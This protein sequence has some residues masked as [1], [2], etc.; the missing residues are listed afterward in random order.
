MSEPRGMSGPVSSPE[1]SVVVPCYNESRNLPLLLERLSAISSQPGIEVVLVN[2]GSTDDSQAVLD[3]LL[4][5]HPFAR[6]VLVPV[7]RGYGYGILS[8][9]R[10]GRGEFLSWTHADLQT[11]PADILRALSIARTSTSPKSTYVKG[12]RRGRPILDRMFTAGMGVFETLYFR[13]S[14]WDVNA[15]PNLFHKEFFARWSDPPHDFSLDLYVLW[16]ARH[17]GMEVVRMPV[18]FPP[19]LHGKSSW[20]TGWL[21][22]WRFVLRTLR[23]SRQLKSRV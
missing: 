14:L 13:K 23:F 2:N 9:L 5:S 17:E 19:R 8:G 15:Q 6:S 7:N 1:L 18:R 11:D 12:R 4:P 22:K 3:R 10:E 20:N 21:S 16:K